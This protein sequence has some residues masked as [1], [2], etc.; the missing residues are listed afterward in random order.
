MSFQA[1]C[2]DELLSDAEEPK[3]RKRFV[4]GI[5]ELPRQPPLSRSTKRTI[6]ASL[7]GALGLNVTSLLALVA[8]LL[9]TSG[10]LGAVS[11]VMAGLA[12]V[13]ALHAVDT[14]ACS[15]VSKRNSPSQ[16]LRT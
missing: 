2:D 15:G 6:F 13:V 16:I 10:L 11:G 3:D 12:T 9:A 14:L 7:V 8:D 5:M 1:K 4:V